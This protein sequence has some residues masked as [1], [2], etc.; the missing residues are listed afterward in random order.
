MQF[1]PPGLPLPPQVDTASF[2]GLDA[3]ATYTMLGAVSAP[4]ETL[5]CQAALITPCYWQLTTRVAVPE[6]KVTWPELAPH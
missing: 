1:A 5:N 3:I 2:R 4:R 6:A